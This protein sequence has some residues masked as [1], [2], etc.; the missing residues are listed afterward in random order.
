MHST[1]ETKFV[2]SQDN[3]IMSWSIDCGFMQ[4]VLLYQSLNLVLKVN[5]Y[6]RKS[7]SATIVIGYGE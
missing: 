5:G 3:L 4:K 6:L 1:L 2:L 7:M